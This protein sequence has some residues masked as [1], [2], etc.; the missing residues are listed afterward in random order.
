MKIIK[1]GGI[2]L[3]DLQCTNGCFL[4]FY[5]KNQKTIIITSFGSAS[6]QSLSNIHNNKRWQRELPTLI[7]LFTYAE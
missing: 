3:I 1:K 4:I 7:T 2:Y 5:P 6:C